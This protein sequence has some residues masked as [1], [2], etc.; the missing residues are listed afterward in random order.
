MRGA[1][2]Q[3]VYRG[4]L[5]LYPAEFRAQFSNQMVQLFTDQLRDARTRG[6]PGG[7][8]MTWLKA[9]GDVAVTAASEHIRRNRTVAHSL[10]APPSAS[11]RVLGM[12]GIAGGLGLIAVF[13]ID[14]SPEL[15]T[16]RLILFS[17]GAMAVIVGVHRRQAAAAPA[18]AWAA[19][20]AALIANAWFL[21]MIVLEIGRIDPIG[22]GNFGLVAFA[23]ELSIWPA[24]AA[25]G[26]VTLRLGV[27]TRWG[28]LALAA[29]SVLAIMGMDR[30]G[31]TSADNPTIFGSLALAGIVLSGIGWILL[32]LDVATR[33]RAS[34]ANSREAPPRE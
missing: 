21:L 12:V 32:G 2:H 13:L 10:T 17:A 25:F 15:N 3:R 20:L 1:G 16:L 31:L 19:A 14:L 7:P 23:A 9:I 8:A 4:M 30:L 18:L 24:D 5:R 33:R 34:E 26:L 6:A 11:S 27:V 22:A 29:G 28:A